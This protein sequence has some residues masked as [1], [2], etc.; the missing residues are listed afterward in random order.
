MPGKNVKI[1]S[2][3]GGEFDCYLAMADGMGPAPGVVLASAVHGVDADIMAIA[4]ELAAGGFIAAA[5]DL[6]WRTIPGPLAHDDDRTKQRSQPRLDRIKEGE[7][8]MADT[9]AHRGKRPEFTGRSLAMR[10]G[11]GGPPASLGP[12][13]LGYAAGISCHGTQMLDYIREL[14]DLGEPVC[15]L[16]GDRDHRAPQDVLNAYR[17]L[18]TRKKNL[19]LHI[20]SG[21][22]HGYMMPGIPKA[23]DRQARQFSM[24]RALAMLEGLG[25]TNA[26]EALSEA[27]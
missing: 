21:V 5:P 25:S 10:F 17:A 18:A 19:E 27:S 24:T 12:K 23:F 15:I 2:R 16:W 22:Q 11:Y 20:F 14:E 1:P 6:F 7:V 4:D 13:R 26:Q 3:E 9:L 8:D